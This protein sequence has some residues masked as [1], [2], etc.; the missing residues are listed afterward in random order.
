MSLSK[1][2]NEVVNMVSN[3]DTACDV[4][5]DH[6][7]VSIALVKNNVAK[8][9]LAVDINKG[10][11]EAAVGNIA[12]AGLSDKIDVR[13]SD[14]LHN[15]TKEDHPDAI[16]IAGMGGALV[17]KI[18]EE[19]SEVVKGASQLVLGPQSEIF[20]VRK[21]LRLNGYTIMKESFVKDMGKYYFII[22]A[23]PAKTVEEDD[24]FDEYS[25]YLIDTRNALYREYLL[26]GIEANDGYMKGMS[27]D[28]RNTLEDKN[29]N[30]KKALSMME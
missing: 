28:K 25:R 7:F 3:C 5:C 21:W 10:P 14:G 4:G 15:V 22:D 13:L 6:G 29:R 24:F 27:P 17:T 20:L 9:A 12:D 2:L 30:I 8:R 11:L 18:L 23:R 26:K 19:G 1:R 16:I